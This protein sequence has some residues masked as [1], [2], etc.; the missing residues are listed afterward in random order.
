MR[1]FQ[2]LSAPR[3]I[4][5][6]HTFETND[7]VQRLQWNLLPLDVWSRA[8]VRDDLSKIEAFEVSDATEL[9]L[10]AMLAG[11]LT[12]AILSEVGHQPSLNWMDA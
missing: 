8:F 6:V 4:T 1:V 5:T 7:K 3:H 9:D 2:L 12:P 11:I 10:V